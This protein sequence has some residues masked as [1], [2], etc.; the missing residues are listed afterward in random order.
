MPSATAIHTHPLFVDRSTRTRMALEGDRGREVLNGL[1]T[2]DVSALAVGSGAYAAALTPKGKLLTDLRVFARETDLLIDVPAAGA[3][4]WWGM[5]RKYINPRLARYVDLTETLTELLV[6]GT[7]AEDAVRAVTALLPAP[8]DYSIAAADGSWV[9]RVPDAGIPSFS[10]FVPSDRAGVVRT[11]LMD[12]GVAPDAYDHFTCARIEAG[13]PLMGVDMSESSL[14]QEVALDRLEAVSYNKGCYTGQET[15][16]RLHFRGHVNKRLIGLQMN[17]AAP[18]GATVATDAV[19]Q[20][21]IVSSVAHSGYFGHIALATLRRE[22]AI[23]DEVLVQ[24]ETDR[25]TATVVDLPF[26]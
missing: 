8:A 11:Q 23:G 21:G 20:A 24:W 2:N 14:V 22:V 1:V 4:S 10:L 15:V 17:D 12:A 16:A 26:S 19:P 5:V 25:I 7:G 3:A 13:R 9:A 6:F 18:Q